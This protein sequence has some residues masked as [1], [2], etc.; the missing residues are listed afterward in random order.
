[1]YSERN[2]GLS[3]LNEG[4]KGRRAKSPDRSRAEERGGPRER[5][6]ELGTPKHE[7]VGRSRLGEEAMNGSPVLRRAEDTGGAKA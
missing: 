2:E 6:G 7:G 1:M 4:E 5:D 3:S